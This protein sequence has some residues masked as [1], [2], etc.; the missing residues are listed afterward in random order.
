M[1]CAL[2]GHL[3]GRLAAGLRHVAGHRELLRPR[4]VAEHGHRLDG[5]HGGRH[6]HGRVVEGGGLA[7]HDGGHGEEDGGADQPVEKCG[8]DSGAVGGREGVH[9]EEKAGEGD[10]HVAEAGGDG[11]A[12][13]RTVQQLTSYVQVLRAQ[14]ETAEKV[15]IPIFQRNCCVVFLPD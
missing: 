13:P 14:L 5:E 9:R 4:P 8:Q 10:E 1:S 3:E 12:L 2:P 11:G 7:P 6:R 15:Q